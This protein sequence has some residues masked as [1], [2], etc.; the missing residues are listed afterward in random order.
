M[1]KTT[2]AASP[3]QRVIYDGAGSGSSQAGLQGPR[4]TPKAELL[5]WGKW[6]KTPPQTR[7]ELNSEDAM[8]TNGEDVI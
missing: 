4:L 3:D 6:G 8:G 5:K 1:L 2:T 7:V